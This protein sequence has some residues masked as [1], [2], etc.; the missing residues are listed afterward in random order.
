MTPE[1]KTDLMKTLGAEESGFIKVVLR[2]SGRM[3]DSVT[4]RLKLRFA[5]A[6][7][8]KVSLGSC[9]DRLGRGE[10]PEV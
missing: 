6:L 9:V 4:K 10:P 2:R 7:S 5:Q 3:I 8:P 1:S